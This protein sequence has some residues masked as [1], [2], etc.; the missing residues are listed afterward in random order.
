MRVALLAL[1][2]FLLLVWPGALR[3]ED[4]VPPAPF[5]VDDVAPAPGERPAG[6]EPVVA[7]GKVP[8]AA[9]TVGSLLTL[10]VQAGVPEAA[11]HVRSRAWQRPDG[12][13]VVSSLLGVD[14]D[15]AA[16]GLEALRSAAETSG[17]KLRELGHPARLLVSW[18]SADDAREAAATWQAHLVVRRLCET[19]WVRVVA[20]GDREAFQAALQVLAAAGRIEPRAAA[21]HALRGRVA[22]ATRNPQ[23]ALESFRLALRPDAP[24]PAPESWLVI[25]AG[26]VGHMLLLQ[27][28]ESV[29]EEALAALQKAVALEE[30]ADS[31]IARFGNRYNLACTLARLGRLDEALA[32]LERSLETG[33]RLLGDDYAQNYEHARERD[34]DMAPLRPDPRFQELMKK[35]AP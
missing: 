31:P 8:D 13:V 20:A 21:F 32:E 1:A 9:P 24:V 6:F 4:E 18:G 5:A 30:H 12:A 28:S 11:V 19:T 15:A 33:K 16:A 3:A 7:A 10:L 14:G 22:E 2:A 34:P 29:L 27:E 25:A 35:Y 17:W 26:R 23:V